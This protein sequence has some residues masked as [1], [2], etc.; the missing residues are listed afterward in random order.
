MTLRITFQGERGAYSESAA[1]NFLARG[2]A[3]VNHAG[4]NQISLWDK[5]PTLLETNTSY[6]SPP[7]LW[8]FPVCAGYLQNP[9][10]N[11]TPKPYLFVDETLSL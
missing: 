3:N 9:S 7:K 11:Y 4:F 10:K 2:L 8:Q 6:V 5:F 1:I